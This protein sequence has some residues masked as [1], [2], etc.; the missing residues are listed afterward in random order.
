MRDEWS[1]VYREPGVPYVTISGTAKMLRWYA[2]NWALISVVSTPVIIMHYENK[3]PTNVNFKN[4]LAICR[5][6]SHNSNTQLVVPETPLGF[7][8]QNI[9]CACTHS[10]HFT[11]G[12]VY[13]S[14]TH[15]I[16][17]MCSIVQY[18]CHQV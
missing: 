14:Q 13:I 2:I 7:L 10:Y 1:Y 9:P 12:F 5:I 4:K 16:I 3:H 15:Q 6:S 17:R 11:K 8:P 18:S